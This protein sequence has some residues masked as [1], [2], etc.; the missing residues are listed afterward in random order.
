MRRYLTSIVAKLRA[1]LLLRVINSVEL[2]SR[3]KRLR[4]QCRDTIAHM[5]HYHVYQ[6]RTT[7]LGFSNSLKRPEGITGVSV[8]VS[9]LQGAFPTRAV[10]D[11][12]LGFPIA[13]SQRARNLTSAL[14]SSIVPLT[15]IS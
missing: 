1:K 10:S 9:N 14:T 11:A 7:G 5:T 2:V 13:P 3:I 8:S 12:R 15:G 6:R 4:L